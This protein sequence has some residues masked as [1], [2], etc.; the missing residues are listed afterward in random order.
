M[1]FTADLHIHSKYSRATSKDL[2]PENLWFW[3]QL[4]GLNV[5]A[6]G[7]CVH[8]VW[9]RELEEK[10]EPAE[11]GLYTLKDKYIRAPGLQVP[12]SCR[13][14]ARFILSTEIS[15][16]YKKNGKV[17]K[18][19]NVILLSGLQAA[20]ALSARLE[21]IG[22]IKSDGRPILGMDAKDLLRLCLDCDPK[23]LFIPAHI[24]T[25]WFSLLGSQSGFDT[26]EECFEDLT[27]CIHAVETGLSSDPPMNWRLTQLDRFFLVSNSDA[28]SA[29][30]LGREANIFDGEFSYDGIYRALS[31]KKE[32]GF[33]GTIEFFPE[34]GKYHFDG[35]RDCRV[36]L[37]P[38]ETL[39]NKGL[40]PACGK[41][42]TVGVMSRVEELGDRPEGKK[43]PNARPYHNLIGLEEI[44]AGARGVGKASK[45]VAQAYRQ[46]LDHLGPEIKVLMEA[47]LKDIQSCAGD[48]AAEGV[49]RMREGK[50]R[51][52]PGY[53]GEFGEISLF[54]AGEIKTIK[55]QLA[56]V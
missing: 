48:V 31:E 55:G 15:C 50:V 19:H 54:E 37:H 28:H 56:F 9:L 27:P 3:A 53:D 1:K 30:K 44:M 25:P 34:E 12:Q 49:R 43:P 24:W 17:R 32:A 42:V 18:V 46:V 4:K 13:F 36:R 26:V 22:N 41:P 40:C 10:L 38:Q 33:K 39:K 16:I 23:A 45:Q 14:P 35:H 2:D 11:P 7:D 47:P 6:T 5:V 8:P 52:A 29:S 51:I 20:A 21:G